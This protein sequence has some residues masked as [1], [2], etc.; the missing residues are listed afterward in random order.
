MYK[1]QAQ[2]QSVSKAERLR[3]ILSR[4][5]NAFRR[6]V[7]GDR[8]ARV[9]PKRVQLE[10]GASAV[11]AKPRRYDP[12]KTSWLAS[13]VAALLAF[14]LVFRNLQVVWS[15][16]AMAVPKYYSFR[17]VSDYKAVNEQVTS[18]GVMPNQE[19]DMVDLLN[20]LLYTSPSPRD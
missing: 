17:L 12:V 1:R 16:P 2:G 6:A 20:C 10:R 11:N 15:S 14:G 19:A 18:P 9:E 13:C 3:G 4:R 8:P 7:R 5:F